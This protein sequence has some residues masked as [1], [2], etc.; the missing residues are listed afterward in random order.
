MVGNSLG[1]RGPQL[2]PGIWLGP[3]LR[4]NGCLQTSR[5]STSS[6]LLPL[7][8]ALLH[9]LKQLVLDVGIPCIAWVLL[10]VV[11]L[12]VSGRATTN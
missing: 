8:D 3:Q 4:L 5:S 9:V 6:A 12:S 1:N 10:V 2:V 7:L 11:L